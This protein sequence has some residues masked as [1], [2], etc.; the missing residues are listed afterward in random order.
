MS[1]SY[2]EQQE[3]PFIEDT[4]TFRRAVPSGMVPVTAAKYPGNLVYE[5]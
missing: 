1:F 3:K 5:K 4:M 2:F